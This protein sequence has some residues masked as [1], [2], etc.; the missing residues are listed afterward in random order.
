LNCKNQLTHMPIYMDVHYIPGVGAID[1]AE[2]HRKDLRIQGEHQC[3]CMTYWIDEARGV[4]FCLIDAPGK[5]VVE[6]MHRRA[7]GLIPHKILEV[8]N[9]VVES[10]LGRIHDPEGAVVSDN[11]LKVFS[12]PAFRILLVTETA[13][14]ILLRHGLGVKKANELLDRQ[15]SIIRKELSVH[16]G[17]EVEHGGC[18][19]I[20]SF[21]SAG[22]A[23]SCAL[24]VEKNLS[25]GE[26]S[27]TSL[28]IGVSAGEPV[29]GGDQLFGDAIR[30]GRYLCSI[31][32]HNKISVSSVVKEL[33]APDHY[34]R[35]QRKLLVLSPP[36]EAL[37]DS[38]FHILEQNWKNPDFTVAE[39]CQT[40][41]MSKSRLYRKTIA[42][43]DL[44]PNLL[45]KEFRLNKARE[46]L[47]RQSSTIAEA[48]FGSG[49]S[50]PSYFT[51][52]FKKRFGLLP[53]MYL[54][55]QQ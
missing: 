14:P 43:W 15:S 32:N 3:K 18:G 19:F 13:D 21:S 16:G 41:S 28:R 52:C 55:S 5:P 39:F 29:S 50:S 40:V 4:V 47:K 11:G 31:T 9:E 27:R 2:A 38:L 17:R 48:T 6:E 26:K 1:V 25:V 36:E 44:S 35:I 10:F 37:V 34:Q 53:A 24:D 33:L 54:H 22:K 42:L 51:K 45:L 49:F 23:V 20:G 8:S 12:D 7:H 30:L 46:L